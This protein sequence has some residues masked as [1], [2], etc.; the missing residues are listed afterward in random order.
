MRKIILL[1]LLVLGTVGAAISN[2][3]P[4]IDGTYVTVNTFQFNPENKEWVELNKAHILLK[5]SVTEG[6]LKLGGS[7][8]NIKKL[9]T[10][11]NKKED[12]LD[13]KF[14]LTNS[15]GEWAVATFILYEKT[16]TEGMSAY[17]QFYLSDK[18]VDISFD[19]CY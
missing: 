18:E 8:Y 19:V 16:N 12:S 7:T 1:L 15:K 11:Y 17:P 14:K 6:T 13:F 10:K 9:K 3:P 5:I 2:E 4:T